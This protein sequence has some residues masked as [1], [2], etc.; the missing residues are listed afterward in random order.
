MRKK[1]H[2]GPPRQ[3]TVQDNSGMLRWMRVFRQ[4]DDGKLE[5]GRV[6]ISHEQ[7]RGLPHFEIGAAEGPK[8]TVRYGESGRLEWVDLQRSNVRYVREQGPDGST[9]Y[10]AADEGELEERGAYRIKKVNEGF[11]ARLDRNRRR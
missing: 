3:E 6:P 2:H 1:R 8:A 7:S 10:R 11:E 9:Y 5:K 4:K